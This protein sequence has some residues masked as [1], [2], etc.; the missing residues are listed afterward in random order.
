M[1]FQHT[2]FCRKALGHFPPPQKKK[3][4]NQ[5]F[6]VIWQTDRNMKPV[7]SPK[8]SSFCCSPKGLCFP[9]QLKIPRRSPGTTKQMLSHPHTS[10]IKFF[11]SKL[12]I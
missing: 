3:P 5:K 4:H 9:V 11:F 2:Q 6:S 10:I 12:L 1:A 7:V 8:Q